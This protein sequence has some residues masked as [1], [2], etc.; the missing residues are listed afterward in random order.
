MSDPDACLHTG[1][2]VGLLAPVQASAGNLWGAVG[3][4]LKLLS[5]APPL[6]P[7]PRDHPM[8][9]SFA[10][11]RL[12]FIQQSAPD[13][14]VYNLSFAWRLS[15]PLNVTALERSFADIVRRHENFRTSFHYQ[16]GQPVQIIS[17]TPLPGLTLR[18]LQSLPETE[19]EAEV[20]RQLKAESRRPFDLAHP[21]LLRTFLLR[22]GGT[23][24][25]LLLVMHH[26]V[27]DAASLGV[28]FRE[29]RAF[30]E[31]YNGGNS[32]VLPQLLIQYADFAVWQRSWLQREILQ[33]QLAYW[34][35]QLTDAQPLLELPADHTRPPKQL[36]HGA[37]HHFKL[38]ATLTEPLN[39]LKRQVGTTTFTVLL[40][41][42]KAL[43]YRHTGQ[44]DLLIGSM[45][46]GRNRI[47]ICNL[48]GFF[49]NTQVLRTR[50]NGDLNFRELLGRV[51]TTV[52]DACSHQDVPFE[53]LVEELRVHRQPDH[54][55]LFQIMF[56]FQSLPRRGL[57]LPGLQTRMLEVDNGTSKFD[58]T[59]DINETPH[60]LACFFEYNTDL[61]TALTIQRL[62][63]H[64][65]N[66]LAGALANPDTPMDKLPLLSATQRKQILVD[67]NQTTR[68]Y[69]R[70][71]CVH[72]L[73]EDQVER[74]PV[75]I[76]AIFENQRLTYGELN[77]RANQ[78]VAHL[79][80]LGLGPESL[81][82]ILMDR[83]LEMLIA[84]L[85]V[86]K[87]GAAYVPLDTAF[88]ADRLAF[89]MA[90]AQIS[91]LLTQS[92]QEP[93]AVPANVQV[94]C[95]DKLPADATV[96]WPNLNIGINS[97]SLAYVIYTS[98]STG[99]PKGVQVLHQAVVNFLFSM[100]AAPGLAASDKLLA[101]TTI[102]FDIAALELFLPLVVGAQ[103]I[104]ATAETTLSPAKLAAE[105][106]RHG[107]TVMQ[108]T[109]TTWRMLIDAGWTGNSRLK[110]LC[111]GEALAPELA[112]KLRERCGALWN[113][114]GPTETTIWSALHQVTTVQS[115]V[116]IGRPIA[117]TEIYLLN[118]RLEPV[119]VGV[120]ADLYIGGDGLA[121]GYL[122]RPELTAEK[123][124]PHPFN[125]SPDARLYHT[126]DLARYLPDGNL[127]CAGRSDQQV[128]IRGFRIELGEIESVLE[129][130]PTVRTALVVADNETAGEARLLAYWLPRPGSSTTTTAL[131]K[132]LEQRLPAYMLPSVF[133]ELK[134]FPTTP[135]GKVD[136][137]RLP[138]PGADRPSL[139]TSFIAPT[140]FLELLL[141][142]IWQEVLKQDKVGINDNFFD[143]G[144]HSLSVIQVI[145]RL[146][147]CLGIQI[148][149]ATFFDSPTIAQLAEK[150]LELLT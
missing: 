126:G 131:R 132:Y 87:A 52:L 116:P 17:S 84:I 4:S 144:G 47:E 77:Q 102:S 128:K 1:A 117:N 134:S 101:V 69:D 107:I 32:A 120:A 50:V 119:P 97:A 67:W 18:D 81:V 110:I 98:G 51:K 89:M 108:A 13:G 143:L 27:C 73:F 63:G 142:P 10:Q 83:S 94:V 88:P 137:S 19:R 22:L 35:A 44:T 112:L 6:R 11:Q 118:S 23:E 106:D 5:G 122:H 59:L 135:N 25:V 85:G 26:I 129:Q 53:K 28:L 37:L 36:F 138:K 38:P 57:E 33:P 139:A 64:F 141:A 113:M 123:F 14:I 99:R 130:H 20:A 55:P 12:W 133:M 46:A 29:M 7:L 104:I 105:I 24:H 49:V 150:I 31:E 56:S 121:R 114:Y 74:T 91:V 34:Q 39:S 148:S 96:V 71:L 60:G 66:L 115:P 9:L 146:N 149:I 70:S 103:V 140:N 127:V 147:A 136:R 68:E 92:R 82:G 80:T 8:P 93:T 124:I 62:A 2:G 43:V 95:V 42:F 72:Q 100:R 21:P 30:Y 54:T 78:V 75:A 65:Q 15:G 125:P 40:A 76:A 16:D 79:Q 86:L 41:A 109:P 48:I 145:S 3:D 45:T 58:L 61:F 111:G 90:D